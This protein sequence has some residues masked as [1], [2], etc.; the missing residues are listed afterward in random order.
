MHAEMMRV[1]CR[2]EGEE[3]MR[4]GAGR[5]ETIHLVITVTQSGIYSV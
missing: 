3:M 2:E 1:G 5:G 4:V